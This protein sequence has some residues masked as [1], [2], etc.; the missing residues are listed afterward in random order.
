MRINLLS[1]GL[2]LTTA[3]LCGCKSQLRW[4]EITNTTQVDVYIKI[5]T[6]VM[7]D[8]IKA[9]G[10]TTLTEQ[11]FRGGSFE[12]EILGKDRKPLKTVTLSAEKLNESD[13]GQT[14]RIRI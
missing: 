10:A 14:L 5:D 9:G 3:V 6:R 4:L 13:D 12:C 8:V 1:V 7:P 2:A 11:V